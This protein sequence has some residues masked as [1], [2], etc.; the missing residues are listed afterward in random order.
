MEEKIQKLIAQILN[1]ANHCFFQFGQIANYVKF[2][3]QTFNLLMQYGKPYITTPNGVDYVLNGVIKIVID[4]S[5]D[6]ITV[7][8]IG[9]DFTIVFNHGIN[10]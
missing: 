4:N 6:D 5:R 2:N 10:K 1:Q 8:I 7:G 9:T 3:E